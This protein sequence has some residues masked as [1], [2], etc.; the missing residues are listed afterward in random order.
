MTRLEAGPSAQPLSTALTRGGVALVANGALTAV[1]GVAY[2]IVAARLFDQ[3]TLGRNSSLVSAMITLSG[4]AQLNY[5]RSLSGLIPRAPRASHLVARVYVVTG[6]L[7]LVI[8][9]A[10]AIIGPAFSSQLGYLRSSSVLVGL[11]AG[12]V[13]VWTIFTLEDTVLASTRRAPVIVV[14]NG[15]FGVAKIALLGAFAWAGLGRFSIFASWVLPLVAI[16]VPVNLF[17]FR[18]ALP[19]AAS[20]KVER[21][22]RQPRW[23]RYDLAGYFLWLVGTLPLPVLV[24]TAL[25]PARAAAFYIPFT[26]AL[27]VDLLSLNLGNALTAELSRVGR[28]AGPGAAFIRR[29]WSVVA[30][31]AAFLALFAPQVLQL[32]GDHY[33][34]QGTSVLRLLMVAALARSV[35]LMTIAVSRAHGLGPRILLLQATASVGT[36]ALAPLL[37]Q[38]SGILGMGLA[39]TLAST[40]AGLIAIRGLWPS[41]RRTSVAS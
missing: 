29:A 31:A 11:F 38:E 19:E 13:M 18:R 30:A 10:F 21:T 6:G 5:A 20:L 41:I 34:A 2:W 22:A 9:G 35:M 1:L 15:I 7:G 23:V 33:R 24:L 3:V 27:A 4:F 36:L 32:F 37:M 39:W 25:G 17:V 12:A 40:A 8:G 14:E 26:I 16:V 28:V